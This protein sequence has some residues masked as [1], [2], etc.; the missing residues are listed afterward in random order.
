MFVHKI[1]GIAEVQWNECYPPKLGSMASAANLK[2]TTPEVR[3]GT[4]LRHARDLPTVPRALARFYQAMVWLDSAG[5]CY[6]QEQLIKRRPILR[7]RC[8]VGRRQNEY[9]K[10]HYINT[11]LKRI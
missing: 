8:T 3:I 2:S 7:F 5:P 6:V 10:A 11:N 9:M 4:T 1:H